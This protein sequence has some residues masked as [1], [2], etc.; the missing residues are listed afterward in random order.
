MNEACGSLSAWRGDIGPGRPGR[1]D[2]RGAATASVFGG[3]RGVRARPAPGFLSIY[4]RSGPCPARRGRPTPDFSRSN[5][6]HRIG[7]MCIGWRQKTAR[8]SRTRCGG[9]T[10][11][12]QPCRPPRPR[13]VLQSRVAC[14]DHICVIVTMPAR[15]G[16]FFGGAAPHRVSAAAV[17]SNVPGLADQLRLLSLPSA[18][19]VESSQAGAS[20]P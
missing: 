13:P 16:G 7:V 11:G 2:V 14:T 4:P 5:R 19:T 1:A 15:G 6:M 9:A 3:V 8:V 10:T 18:S 17:T 20:T 12:G